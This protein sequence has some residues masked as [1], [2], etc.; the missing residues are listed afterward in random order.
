MLWAVMCLCFFGFLRG[1]EVVAHDDSNFDPTHHLSF[2]DI[3]TDSLSN[4]SS[5]LVNI[6]QSK[7]DPF[8]SGVKIVVGRN[9]EDL[10]AVAAVLAYMSLR[11][12]GEGP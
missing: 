10:C 12:P 6:K 4:A 7:T 2:I 9:R 8:R 3:T 5:L 1:G 11:D